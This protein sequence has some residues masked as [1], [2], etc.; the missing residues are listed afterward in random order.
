MDMQTHIKRGL[1]CL[2]RITSYSPGFAAKTNAEA[3]YCYP[4][5]PKEIEFELL[6]LRGKPAPWIYKMASDADLARIENELL[7]FMQ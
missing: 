5:E 4:G 2:A 3:D 7:E 1:P 6:T